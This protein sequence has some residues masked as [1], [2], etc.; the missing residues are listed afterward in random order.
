MS[1][2]RN[3]YWARTT[4]RLACVLFFATMVA[5]QTANTPVPRTAQ[6]PATRKINPTNLA[7]VQIPP[8]AVPELIKMTCDEA[9]RHLTSQKI[10]LRLQCNGESQSA[11]RI[12]RQDPVPKTTVQRGSV[13]Q[14]YFDPVQQRPKF[15]LQ[16]IDP[17]KLAGV[18]LVEVPDLTKRTCTDAEQYLGSNNIPLRVQCHADSNSQQFISRQEPLPKTNVKRGSVINAYFDPAETRVQVPLLQGLTPDDARGVLAQQNLELGSVSIVKQTG[19]PGRIGPQKP[20]EGSWARPGTKVSVWVYPDRLTITPSTAS[21]K[22]G[23]R[24]EVEAALEP[25]RPGT[26]YEFFWNDPND[27]AGKTQTAAARAGHEYRA[28]GRYRVYAVTTNPF[29]GDRV[30]SNLEAV[31]VVPVPP[32]PPTIDGD[33]Q[34]RPKTGVEQTSTT[35]GVGET[36]SPKTP[37]NEPAKSRKEPQSSVRPQQTITVVLRFNPQKPK[38]GQPVR[39][40]AEVN[41]PLPG[42]QFTYWFGDGQAVRA[43]GD[44]VLHKYDGGGLYTATV[45]ASVKGR[46]IPSPPQFLQVLSVPPPVVPPTYY[47]VGVAFVAALGATARIWRRNSKVKKMRQRLVITSHQGTSRFTE[48]RRAGVTPPTVAISLHVPDGVYEV[49]SRTKAGGR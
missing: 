22:A 28:P 36:T 46:E 45:T 2:A 1:S 7:Q 3:I 29:T 27:A 38:V 24:L 30:Q 37:A 31:E 33:P 49:A 9:Q 41:P 23:E 8:I 47:A 16:R 18:L 17:E 13:V 39:F 35:S 4:A 5:S 15:P 26:V 42:A 6:I 12:S 14:A 10:P 48:L 19:D 25:H 11:P 32:P 21:L 34:S 20:R 44:S 40:H 43:A